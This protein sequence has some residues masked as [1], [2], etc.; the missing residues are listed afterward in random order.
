MVDESDWESRSDIGKTEAQDFTCKFCEETFKTKKE[1]MHH[2]K[3]EHIEKVA[4]C[5][6]YSS[7]NCEYG[8]YNCWFTHTK[9][10]I[11]MEPAEIECNRCE[12]VFTAQSEFLNKFISSL[13][14]NV[15]MH[16]MVDVNTI[17]HDRSQISGTG[18]TEHGTG[19]RLGKNLGP[20]PEKSVIWDQA[21]DD[22]KS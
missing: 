4:N 9:N 20:V 6:K 14:L 2:N 13:F 16:K 5:W 18:P 11:V 10:E 8:E 21:N 3:N 19:P 1:V 22:Y 17:Q 15:E 7:G 12:Q